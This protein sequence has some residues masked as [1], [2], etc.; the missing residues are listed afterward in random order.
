MSKK[1]S[2]KYQYCIFDASL[3]KIEYLKSLDCKYHII[4]G[5]EHCDI[6]SI[7]GCIVWEHNKTQAT[8]EYLLREINVFPCYLDAPMF[9]EQFSSAGFFWEGGD[10]PVKPARKERV[11]KKK[12]SGAKPVAASVANS[13]VTEGQVLQSFIGAAEA[14]FEMTKKSQDAFIDMTG[15]MQKAYI[16]QGNNFHE[17]LIKQ[18]QQIATL[19]QNNTNNHSNNNNTTNSHNKVINVQMF[20]NEQCADAVTLIDFVKNLHI[21]NEDL[22]YANE[23]GFAEGVIRVFEKGLE[24]YNINTRPI[25]CTDLKRD[26]MHIKEENGW[27]REQ[28]TESKNIQKAI[29]TVSAKNMQKLSEFIKDNPDYRNVRSP[30]YEEYLSFMKNAIGH[31]GEN[32]KNAKKIVKELAK[33]VYMTKDELVVSPP[34]PL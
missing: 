14:A 31:L 25:H 21:E 17:L 9:K 7:H 5:S 27:T 22:E 24:H 28:G 1:A 32:E 10:I 16:E 20:L 30:K 29:D 4:A 26:T 13:V 15:K 12:E 19:T 34:P 18:N 23:H 2:R 33:R 8:A 11:S 6:Y 3:E